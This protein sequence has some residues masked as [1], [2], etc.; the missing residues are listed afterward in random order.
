[1]IRHALL[2]L[3]I[4]AF[5][6][7]LVEEK[8]LDPLNWT[9]KYL[10]DL[11]V[12]QDDN[13]EMLRKIKARLTADNWYLNQFG[14]LIPS[15]ET[16]EQDL[17]TQSNIDMNLDAFLEGVRVSVD[18]NGK[19]KELVDAHG[20]PL[21][22]Q[23]KW[24]PTEGG[25]KEHKEKYFIILDENT[26]TTIKRSSRKSSDV[27]GETEDGE[28]LGLDFDYLGKETPDD[29]D[30]DDHDEQGRLVYRRKTE[31]EDDDDFLADDFNM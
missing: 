10:R 25:E 5:R 24:T 19:P 9:T 15:E 4:D 3:E 23:V 1:M 2:D 21:P 6:A 17:G 16:P 26:V 13:L 28:G 31:L 7:H 11:I 12:L 29:D 27:L 18:S 8:Y 20:K 30:D 14:E 22:V